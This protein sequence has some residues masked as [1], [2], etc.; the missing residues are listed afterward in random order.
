M[1]S[2]LKDSEGKLYQVTCD[3]G[4]KPARYIFDTQYWF[5]LLREIYLIG[6]FDLK[7]HLTFPDYVNCCDWNLLRKCYLLFSVNQYN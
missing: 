5:G 7:E 3:D 4:P 6:N 1:Q 2:V